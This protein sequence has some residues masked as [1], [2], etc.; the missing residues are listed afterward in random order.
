[1]IFTA[2]PIPGAFV[3]DIERREDERG[4]F[5]RTFC[6]RELEAHGLSAAVAQCSISHN[7]LR[8]TLRGMHWQ[9]ASAP[10]SKLVRCTRGAIR[11]VIIDLRRESPAY[12]RHFAVELNAENRRGLFIPPLCAHG[13]QTLADDTEVF[14]QIDQAHTPEAARGLPFDDPAFAIV[15]P[16]PV[17]VI[18][19]KDRRWPRFEL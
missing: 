1:M 8:G 14:Y 9:D 16:L 6:T 4:F 13:F 15:W 3:V 7:R 18:A 11:D 2:T 10:E 17:T 19:D 5:A 12:G